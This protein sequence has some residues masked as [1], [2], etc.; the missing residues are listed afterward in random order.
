[1]TKKHFVDMATEFGMM[2]RDADRDYASGADKDYIH[3]CKLDTLGQTVKAFC[4]VAKRANPR[5]D[6]DNFT[7]FVQEVRRGERDLEGRKVK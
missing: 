2:Y 5:F 1:M 6:K 4:G 7:E 3:V